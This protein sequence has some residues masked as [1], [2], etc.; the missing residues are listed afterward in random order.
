[1]VDICHVKQPLVVVEDQSKLG[2][3]RHWAY[4]IQGLT[5][6]RSYPAHTTSGNGRALPLPD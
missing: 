3:S 1:M 6:G 2:G 5:L 4:E